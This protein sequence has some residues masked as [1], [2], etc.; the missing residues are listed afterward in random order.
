MSRRIVSLLIMTTLLLLMLSSIGFAANPE[1]RIGVLLPLSGSWAEYANEIRRGMDIAVDVIREKGGIKI[2]GQTHDIRLIYTDA[3][4]VQAGVAE[5]ERLIV[6]EKVHILS[7]S[8]GSQVPMAASTVAERHK[9]IFWEVSQ[10]ADELTE[11]GYKYLFRTSAT[12]SSEGRCMAQFACDNYKAL[13]RDKPEDL[14]FAICGLD[15]PYGISVLDGAEERI[16]E[17]GAKL[18]I[19]E[20]YAGGVTD[21]SS[22]VLRIRSTNPDVVLIAS[23]VDDGMLFYRQMKEQGV[24]VKCLMGT[25]SSTGAELFHQEF[26]IDAEYVLAGNHPGELSPPGYA[27]DLPDFMQ[28]Y[29]QKHNRQHLFSIHGLKAYQSLLVL[30]DVLGR[31]KSVNSDDIREAAHTTEIPANTMGNG[32]GCKFAP[33]GDPMEGTNL[34]A[35]PIITQWQEGKMYMIWPMSYPG[36]EPILPLPTWEERAKAKGT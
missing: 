33:P 9:I 4:D 8:F 27:P 24:Y 6:K 25:G 3:P 11:R 2:N 17:I 12:S 28:R 18:L 19:K 16:K 20:H 26:G 1:V 35:Y 36:I 15:T 34:W 32:W 7:G 14:T 29:R 22:L 30:W 31:S 21:L 10:G 23:A 5:A 13:G